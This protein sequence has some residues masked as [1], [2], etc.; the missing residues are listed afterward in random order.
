[1]R[2]KGF[3]LIELLVVIAIIAILA[4]IL[5]PVFARAREKARQA[6]CQSNLKQINTAFLM[7]VQDYDECW[8]RICWPN[9]PAL[10]NSWPALHNP[11]GSRV[12]SFWDWP[13]HVYT[14]TKNA[15]IFDCPTS[16]DPYPPA[17]ANPQNYDGNYVYNHNG[18]N[19][20]AGRVITNISQPAEVV[21][22][23]DGGDAYLI[24]GADT[25]ARLLG[26]L[27]EDWANPNL[28]RATRHN[29][30]ANIG[31]VDGHVKTQTKNYL[32]TVNQGFE[33]LPYRIYVR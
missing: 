6:S 32:V 11:S 27:D 14:Y 4:A 8:P 1:M 10:Q 15:P 5:F 12:E 16:P 26:T 19:C 13:H 28:E 25:M 23:L 20:Q 24:P 31:Y 29:D 21:L 22:V 17:N 9:T 33:N 18:V 30:M 7:Y 2:S 3:T